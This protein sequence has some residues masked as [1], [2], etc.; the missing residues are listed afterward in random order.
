MEELRVRK[1]SFSDLPLILSHRRK[2]FEEMRI[3]GPAGL[4]AMDR[5]SE[6]FFS[7]AMKDGSYRGWL[8]EDPTGRVV[9]GG[10]IG[11]ISFPP[12]PKNP[13]SRRATIFN[14]YTEPEFRRRGLARKLMNLM[15]DWCRENGF[16]WVMLHASEAGRPLYESM[17][18]ERTSE[19]QLSLRKDRS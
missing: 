17:G 1:A 2:M 9:A 15:I 7:A 6:A 10:G 18:F 14:V 11:L 8:V 12:N 19:M 13:S 16:A 3:G 5:E 4:D